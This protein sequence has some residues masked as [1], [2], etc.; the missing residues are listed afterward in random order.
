MRHLVSLAFAVIALAVQ[1]VQ[2]FEGLYPPVFK[3]DRL[4]IVEA[5]DMDADYII[6]PDP[7]L[8][9]IFV[10]GRPLTLLEMRFVDAFHRPPAD[11]VLTPWL[12]RQL[13]VYRE[14]LKER[15]VVTR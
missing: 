8:P 3:G 10:A 12:V 5:P 7:E 13:V 6:V 14:S 15:Q 4:D 2:A 1:P 11:R 9:P